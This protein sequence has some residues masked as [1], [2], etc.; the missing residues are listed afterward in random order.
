MSQPP[1]AAEGHHP[2]YPEGHSAAWY[3]TAGHGAQH[4]GGWARRE[5][6]EHLAAHLRTSFLVRTL[7]VP[8]VQSSLWRLPGKEGPASTVLG[9][10]PSAGA[11]A[12]QRRHRRGGGHGSPQINLDVS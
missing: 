12:T 1:E 10:A 2:P 11:T 7:L 4:G 6:A 5:A 3:P 9:T 8:Q